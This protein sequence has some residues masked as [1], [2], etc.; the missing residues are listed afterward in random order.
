MAGLA[1]EGVEALSVTDALFSR[2]AAAAATRA[3]FSSHVTPDAIFVGNDH[4]AF[5]VI[6]VLRAELGLVP[7]QDVSIVGYDD[8]AM[9]SW[10]SFDLTT[11]RQPA[12]RMVQAVVTQLLSQIEGK[13]PLA[14]HIEIDGPLIVRGSARI[15]QGW[16]T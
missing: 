9:A 12:N 3:L 2:E 1:A 15:P 10:P 4:M 5:A 13:E 16:T 6:E 8:V 7:G 11:V 14:K